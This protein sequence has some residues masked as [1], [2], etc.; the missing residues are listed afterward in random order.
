MSAIVASRF[1]FVQSI[2]WSEFCFLLS[3]RVQVL[4]GGVLLTF[5]LTCVVLLSRKSLDKFSS[6]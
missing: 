2:F 6:S 3:H 1:V 4:S 5:S